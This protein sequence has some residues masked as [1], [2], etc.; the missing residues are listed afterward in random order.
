MLQSGYSGYEC[1]LLS[2]LCKYDF[3]KGALFVL[4]WARVRRV[5]RG[6]ISADMMMCGGFARIILLLPL[7]A[8]CMEAIYV[9]IM[10]VC[11]PVVRL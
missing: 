2:A 1:D 6:C 3:R 11:M 5:T 10:F 4:N 9:C 8:R 7:V